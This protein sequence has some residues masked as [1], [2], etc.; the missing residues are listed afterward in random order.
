MAGQR[1]PKTV[2]DEHKKAMQQGRQESRIVADYL[3]GLRT[4]KPKR[5][6][7]RTADTITKRLDAINDELAEANAINELKLVQERRDL[8][9]ELDAMSDDID[10]PALERAFVGVAKAYGDRKGITYGS[11]REVGVPPAVLKRAGITRGR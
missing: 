7:K 8:Q 6:R 9:A 1:G 10:M 11:W 2:T 3:E 5:G 4:T